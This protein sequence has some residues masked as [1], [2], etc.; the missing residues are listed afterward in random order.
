MFTLVSSVTNASNLEWVVDLYLHIG[1]EKTGTTSVQR[2]L[3]TN[4]TLLAEH[5]ILYPSAPGRENH[6]G[7][8]A[9]AIRERRSG[10]DVREIYGLNSVEDVRRFRETLRDTL[11][12]EV[13]AAPYTKAVMSGEHCS[14]RLVHEDEVAW[15]QEFLQQFFSKVYIVVY[16][17]RQDD[18]FLS[19]YSTTVKGGS[20]SP[21]ALPTG[22]NLNRRY[23]FWQLTSRWANVFGRDQIIC[24]KYEKSGLK[25]DSIVEDVLSVTGIPEDLPFV[26]PE[27]LNESLDAES[28]EFLRLFNRFY[29]QFEKDGLRPNRGNLVKLLSKISNGPLATLPDDAL[30]RFLAHFEESNRQVAEEYFGGPISGSD[31]PLFL[32]RADTRSRASDVP[33]S[34]ERAVEICAWLWQQKQTQVERFSARRK[35]RRGVQGE[36]ANRK[37]HSRKLTAGS[38]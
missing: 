15:L 29:S 26:W 18:F 22:E 30:A 24:R 35:E 3:R 38:K 8:T 32:P 5:S 11:K 19:T 14:S 9:A 21:M 12:A 7:L 36:P 25:N 28:L 1:T 13:E 20:T 37:G 6:M 23:D 4:R 16:L 33:L 2:F 34:V 10:G 17:R 27:R 31:N